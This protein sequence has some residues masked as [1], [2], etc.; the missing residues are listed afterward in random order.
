[1][2]ALLKDMTE[3]LEHLVYSHTFRSEKVQK[4]THAL[5]T[6]IAAGLEDLAGKIDP[7]AAPAETPEPPAPAEA[8]A[9]AETPAAPAPGD[10][11]EYQGNG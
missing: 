9:P 6:R 2:Q 5:L 8:P 3:V 10:A 11:W 1:M 4:R 7:P